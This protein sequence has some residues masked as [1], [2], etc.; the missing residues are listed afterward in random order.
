VQGHSRYLWT[1]LGWADGEFAAK[2]NGG[3]SMAMGD[4]PMGN[5]R[6]GQWGLW[7]MGDRP[8]LG[9]KHPNNY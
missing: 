7:A 1:N 4:E 2:G 5:R 3:L 9:E 6:Y 8:W